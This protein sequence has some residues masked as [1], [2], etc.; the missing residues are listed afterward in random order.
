MK[1][2]LAEKPFPHLFIDNFIP[3]AALVRAAA[4]SFNNV[5]DWVEYNGN[6][7]NQIQFCSK[8]G[9][10][11]IPSPALSILDYIAMHFDPNKMFGDITTDAF[12]D[13]SHFGGGAMVTPNSNGEGGYLGMHVDALSHGLHDDWKREY[14]VIL[15]LSEEYDSSFDLLLH[16]GDR[17]HTRV[18]YGFNRL[19]AFKCS[20][21]SWHGVNK[22]TQGLDRKTL[23]VMHWSTDD[24]GLG[25]LTKAKFSGDLSFD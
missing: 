14:S 16:D 11:N 15:G 10:E 4:E 23:G 19:W 3:S 20:D 25:K 22:I 8:L 24:S 12:P 9:R 6:D 1:S 5:D 2:A 21:S 18:P 13:T 17:Y 7:S